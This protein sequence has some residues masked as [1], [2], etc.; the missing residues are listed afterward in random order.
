MPT[1]FLSLGMRKHNGIEKQKKARDEN[2]FQRQAQSS[3]GF[4]NAITLWEI[5]GGARNSQT[6]YHLLPLLSSLPL[7]LTLGIN[8]QIL[9]SGIKLSHSY[10]KIYVPLKVHVSPCQGSRSCVWQACHGSESRPAGEFASKFCRHKR[11]G[12]RINAQRQSDT[13][14]DRMWPSE[15]CHQIQPCE[16]YEKFCIV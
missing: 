2:I 1:L 15:S 14:Q 10:N 6:E 7:Y 5:T 9:G 13:E 11:G 3:A 8:I 16:G 12:K 4:D